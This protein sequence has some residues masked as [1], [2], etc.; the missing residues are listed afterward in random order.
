MGGDDGEPG[1]GEGEGVEGVYD[2]VE[3]V[4]LREDEAGP[5]V[6]FAHAGDQVEGE[7]EDEEGVDVHG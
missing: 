5:R 7:G 3:G 2:G 1:D 4:G 6:L